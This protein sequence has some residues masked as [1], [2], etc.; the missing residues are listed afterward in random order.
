M[1]SLDDE[2]KTVKL[3]IGLYCR[4]HHGTEGLCAECRELADYAESRIKAC[5]YGGGKPACSRCPIHCYKPEMRKKIT[6]VMRFAGPTMA[7]RHPVMAI[8]HLAG[9][10]G[11]IAR[12]T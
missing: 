6:D 12:K 2:V 7:W 9:L 11:D 1:K 10:K 3:M 5:P 8:R 4:H